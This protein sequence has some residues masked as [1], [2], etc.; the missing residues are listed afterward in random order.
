[1][2]PSA[3]K[4]KIYPDFRNPYA[5]ERGQLALLKAAAMAVAIAAAGLVFSLF[6]FDFLPFRIERPYLIPWVIATGIVITAPI[7]YLKRIGELT[8]V[9]P[10]VFA[11]ATYFFPIFFLGGWSLVF[12]L[13]N[14]YYLAFVNDPEYDLPLTFLYVILGFGALSIGFLVSPGRKLGR[15]IGE[16]LPTG[17]LTSTELFV[18]SI[19]FLIGGFYST[20][21]ALELGQI[22][23]QAAG[24]IYGDV[25]S[26]N[27]YLTVI[28]PTSSF[29][30]WLVFFQQKGWS[31]NKFVILAAQVMAA[32]FM[33]LALGGKSS[34]LQSVLYL[35]GA[36]VLVRRKILFKNWM[37]LSAGLT[38]ALVVG[39]IY[40]TTFR[41]L[42]G[43]AD[44]I[45]T[46]S[47]FEIAYDTFTAIGEVDAGRRFEESFYQLAE[48]LEIASSLAV[49]VS[50]YEA[51][52]PYEAEY[53]LEN[54]IW[55][56]TW[57]AFIPRFIW[58]DKPQIA[59]NYSYNEL[60]FGYGGFGLAITSMGDLLRNFGPIGVPLGMFLLGFLIRVFY[61]SLIE[62]QPFSAWRGTL[63][64][65]V[66]TKISYDS[67]YGEILPTAIRVAAIVIIQLLLIKIIFKILPLR[68]M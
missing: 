50:N 43:N 68:R 15:R 9:H 2:T 19:V 66:L 13:S 21:V 32:V 36:F 39:F 59:D 57:T 3:S 23:Y 11:A 60:Y 65:L 10:L 18:G 51:L 17:D 16:K 34:L 38:L 64:F 5:P 54:N 45:S 24:T 22:G 35:F 61:A 40:G 25:G 37:W 8:L 4:S 14:Y 47:Y 7:I 49:V 55:Q 53:G 28:V 1:M 6:G 52:K 31:I 20:L 42:K 41:D 26:L 12:G 29:L 27:V 46:E 58:K 33:L 48:R 56:Y 67:F 62:G 63:Y 44:R 30:L